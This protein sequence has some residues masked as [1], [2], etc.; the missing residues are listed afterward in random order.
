MDTGAGS[1]AVDP[2]TRRKL[3]RQ[4]G[5]GAINW[6]LMIAGGFL[7]SVAVFSLIILVF[8]PKDPGP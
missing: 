4:A 5:P 1:I 8:G 6:L 7:T 3:T 2:Q